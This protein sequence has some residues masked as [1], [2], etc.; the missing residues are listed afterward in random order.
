MTVLRRPPLPP[1]CGSGGSLSPSRRT[2]RSGRSG[3]ARRTTS[4]AAGAQTTLRT[5]L[6]L[7]SIKCHGGVSFL[8]T[9][10]S[11][12]THAKDP[13]GERLKG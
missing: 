7:S 6:P 11:K 13:P 8:Q 5:I 10:K 9:W 12:W 3:S 1:M 2:G 4:S